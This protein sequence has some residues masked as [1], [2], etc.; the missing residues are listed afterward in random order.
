MQTSSNDYHISLWRQRKCFGTCEYNEWCSRVR[1]SHTNQLSHGGGGRE[2]RR[3]RGQLAPPHWSHAPARQ[4]LPQRSERSDARATG[5][6]RLPHQ[7]CFHRVGGLR[8]E[9]VMCSFCLAQSHY[10]VLVKCSCQHCAQIHVQRS[11]VAVCGNGAGLAARRSV[12]RVALAGRILYALPALRL[13][14]RAALRR[15]P[16]RHRVPV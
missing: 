16:H 13:Q 5:L 1:V 10:R 6:R 9:H 8:N 12:L 7:R 2:R 15:T 11:R 14:Q 3:R 4:R